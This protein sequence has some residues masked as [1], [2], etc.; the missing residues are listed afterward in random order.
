M[1]ESTYRIG[2]GFDV[3]R[4]A[5]GRTLVLGGV[6]IDHPMGLEGHS[7]AD[8]LL[9]ALCD[10]I[11][12]AISLGDIGQHFPSDDPQFKDVSSLVLL[13]KVNA[14]LRQD[15]WRVANVDITVICEQPKIAPYAD[16]IRENIAPILDLP[17]DAVSIKG[18]TTEKLGFTGREEGIAAMAV[19][20]VSR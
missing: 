19:A 4:L 3:H 2:N 11:L 10:A 17:L 9:H 14:M 1:V 8:V 12:G 15:K 5:S 16:R 20:L 13:E 6:Q 7:D 18:T